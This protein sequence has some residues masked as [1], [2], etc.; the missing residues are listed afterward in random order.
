VFGIG[1]QSIRRP[2]CTPY[3]P[4]INCSVICSQAGRGSVERTAPGWFHPPCPSH[5]LP[6]KCTVR[7][8]NP[9]I[10]RHIWQQSKASVSHV[11]KWPRCRRVNDLY[12]GVWILYHRARVWIG[13]QMEI[14]TPDILA[15]EGCDWPPFCACQVERVV[16]GQSQGWKKRSPTGG[17]TAVYIFD[18]E[19]G[20]DG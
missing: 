20:M 1:L 12:A 16:L 10:F 6:F 19:W 2:D 11:F 18:Q 5:C 8:Q 9:V 14:S 13:Q 4:E 3:T 17:V 15:W 7:S